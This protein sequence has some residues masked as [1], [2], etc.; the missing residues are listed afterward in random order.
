MNPNPV[1]SHQYYYLDARCDVRGPF[2]LPEMQ[3]LASARSLRRG[4]MVARE[5]SEEWKEAELFPDIALAMPR[6]P[7]ASPVVPVMVA[8]PS[9]ATPE[10]GVFVRPLPAWLLPAVLGVLVAGLFI[11]MFVADREH[12]AALR[13]RVA[14][15]SDPWISASAHIWPGVTL[16]YGPN[17]TQSGTVVTADGETVTINMSGSRE[18]KSRAWVASNYWVRADDPALPH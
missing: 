10:L 9:P 16:Y 18:Q 11:F 7:I 2:S 5:G 13:D 8:A 1:R 6:P 4:M 12:Q 3:A 15:P 14:A 17:K